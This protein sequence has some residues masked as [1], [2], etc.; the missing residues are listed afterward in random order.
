M[1]EFKTAME[2]KP[3]YFRKPPTEVFYT[4]AAESGNIRLWL[5]KPQALDSMNELNL[6]G[7]LESEENKRSY[8]YKVYILMEKRDGSTREGYLSIPIYLES[9]QFNSA[10]GV[11][12]YDADRLLPNLK[13]N[14]EAL[15]VGSPIEELLKK[16]PELREI[17]FVEEAIKRCGD[18]YQTDPEVVEFKRLKTATVIKSEQVH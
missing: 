2:G 16:E 8:F 15:R 3:H 18:I 10:L 6:L 5:D 14:P 13:S 12:Y 17:H 4:A 1:S 11:S 7:H 9:G